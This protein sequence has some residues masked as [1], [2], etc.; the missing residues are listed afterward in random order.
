M[1][2]FCQDL[3]CGFYEDF[4]EGKK[5][6]FKS[7]PYCTAPLINVHPNSVKEVADETTGEA[8]LT[9]SIHPNVILN[10]IHSMRC[11]KSSS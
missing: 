4:P 7:C 10:T 3:K 1:S 5:F 8:I 11:S 6:K 2:K 9:T